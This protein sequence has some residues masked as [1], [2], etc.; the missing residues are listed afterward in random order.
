M[1]SGVQKQGWTW[2]PEAESIWFV[3]RLPVIPYVRPV[4]TC[5]DDESHLTY[6][7]TTRISVGDP[8]NEWALPK[9]RSRLEDIQK[10]VSL[11]KNSTACFKGS[12]KVFWLS[13]SSVRTEEPCTDSC[14]Y[15]TYYS[16]ARL[17]ILVCMDDATLR[18]KE[19]KTKR[20]PGLKFDSTK[21]ETRHIYIFYTVVNFICQ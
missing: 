4:K 15:F 1:M 10:H 19:K 5:L 21:Q 16:I 6:L 13:C 20:L 18:K 9:C 2:R 11:I 12:E 14:T 7:S 17:H 3:Q 8:P